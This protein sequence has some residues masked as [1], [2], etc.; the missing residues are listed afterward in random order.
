MSI[1]K[2]LENETNINIVSQD[3]FNNFATI[4]KQRQYFL[5]LF[6]NVNGYQVS[7]EEKK[8]LDLF[9]NKTFTYSE[10]DFDGFKEILDI[11]NPP[12]DYVFFD[13][14]S[15]LGKSLILSALLTPCKKLVGREK[16]TSLV[17]ENKAVFVNY[18]EFLKRDYSNVLVP[19]LDLKEDSFVNYSFD[20]VDVVFVHSTCY[21]DELMKDLTDKLLQLKQ[22]A[23]VITITK[24]IDHPNFEC[25]H[26][27][28]YKMNWG[29]PTV[30]IYKKI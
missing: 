26:K 18:V 7:Y 11:V 14:G 15:G 20:D 1:D 5:E 17:E 25:V 9:E 13:C 27:G 6:K 3:Y 19:E 4:D 24:Q 23:S 21:D 30:F 2:T 8:K 16:L 12:N 29:S 22:G 10:V 28:F